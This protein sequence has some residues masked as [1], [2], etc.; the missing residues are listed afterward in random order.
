MGIR[1]ESEVCVDHVDTVWGVCD[2]CE[3]LYWEYW[4]V[5][6][7]EGCG[8]VGAAG[9]DGQWGVIGR[10]ECWVAVDGV[11]TLCVLRS[12]ISCCTERWNMLSQ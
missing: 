1:G 8:E 6:D 5:Y 9:V 12:D 10:R 3:L 4:E 11:G 2:C 7:G